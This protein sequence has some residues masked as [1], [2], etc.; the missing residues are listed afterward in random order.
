GLDP[1]KVMLAVVGDTT[2]PGSIVLAASPALKKK[3]G[4]GN[5]SRYFELPSDSDI[6]IVQ[7]NMA[8]YLHTS[9]KI[10]QL[11]N[12]YAPKEAIHPYSIDEIWVTVNGL[13]RLLGNRMEIAHHIKHA[14]LTEFG[15]T[16]TIGIGDNKFLAKVV[17]DLHAKKSTSGIAIC[18]YEDVAEKLWPFPVERI[19]GIG[20]R[21][22]RN[23][24][25]LGM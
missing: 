16:C 10:T 25:R 14:I 22:K 20:T 21:M 9:L 11:L 1:M 6:Y 18:S 12:R 19:W 4:I 8:S 5:V 23:L 3:H 24:H 17:M 13:E 7:A 2:R 15:I